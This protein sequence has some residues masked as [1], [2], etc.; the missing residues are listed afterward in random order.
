M[1]LLDSIAGAIGGQSGGGGGNVLDRIL[2]GGDHAVHQ[3][4]SPDQQQFGQAVQQVPRDQLAGIFGQTAR[5]M[6]GQQYRDHVTPGVG[7]TNPLGMLKGPVMG[8]VAGALMKHLMG[9]NAAGGSGMLGSVLGGAMGGGGGGRGGLGGLL[10][11]IP[12][13]TTSD[14]QQMDESQVAAL[15]DYTR[16]HD[17]DAYGRAMADVGHQEP[18]ALGPLLGGQGLSSVAQQLSGLLSGRR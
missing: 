4:G 14:P 2:G 18:G 17:P 7:G 11:N 6:D 9:G 8:L 13:L 15:A 10:G 5:Q 16:Q 3:S 1:G 12:G